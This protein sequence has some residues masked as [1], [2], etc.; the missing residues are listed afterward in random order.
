MNPCS[1]PV[2]DCNASPTA[3]QTDYPETEDIARL[4]QC[5]VRVRRLEDEFSAE[6][7]EKLWNSYEES[8]K[9]KTDSDDDGDDEDYDVDISPAPPTK[10]RSGRGRKQKRKSFLKKKSLKSKYWG[11][12]ESSS[13]NDTT[14]D[15]DDD[16]QDEDYDPLGK[17]RVK[18]YC[19]RRRN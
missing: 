11:S 9:R 10:R 17:R 2:I 19:L 4:K 16:E 8:L 6:F 14:Y 5:F 1:C 13:D 18:N 7:V 3:S 12:S 15:D